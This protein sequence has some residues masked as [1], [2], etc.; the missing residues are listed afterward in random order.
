MAEEN[1][2]CDTCDKPIRMGGADADGR[3]TI[4]DDP[5]NKRGRHYSCNPTLD[6][7]RQQTEDALAKAETALAEIRKIIR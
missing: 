7:V 3:Y 5:E 4:M 6:E 1:W 2:T